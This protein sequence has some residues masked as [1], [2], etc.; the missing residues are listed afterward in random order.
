MSRLPEQGLEIRELKAAKAD[1]A[2]LK[3]HIDAL[4]SLK[5]EYKEKAGK[6]YAPGPTA[7]AAQ[8]AK[9]KKEAAAPAPAPAGGGG[10][11]KE[12]SPAAAAISAKIVAKVNICMCAGMGQ[13][14]SLSLYLS[15]SLSL[16]IYLFGLL[17][18]LDWWD[19][20]AVVVC[21]CSMLCLLYRGRACLVSTLLCPRSCGLVRSLVGWGLVATFFVPVLVELHLRV[22]FTATLLWF[23]RHYKFFVVVCKA[24]LCESCTNTRM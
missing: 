2:A 3:P 1:K 16:P 11:A 17:L 9:A 8:P 12:E 15:V 23:G 22:F 24:V 20:F 7:A 18:S 4:L 19:C 5:A 14:G 6:D 13:V 21:Y 10:A